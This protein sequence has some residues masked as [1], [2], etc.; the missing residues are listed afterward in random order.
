M[1]EPLQPFDWKSSNYERPANSWVCGRTCQSGEPCRLGPSRAGECQVQS[2]CQPEEKNGK[3][4]CTRSTINGGKCK[5]GPTPEGTCCQSDSQCQPRRTLIAKRRLLGVAATIMALSFSLLIFS[6]SSPSALL[7]PGEVTDS[8]ANFETDC[9]ACHSAAEGGITTWYQM[10]FDGETAFKDS[11]RCLKCHTD[12]GT[13]ALFAHGISVKKLSKVTEQTQSQTESTTVPF[14]LQLASLTGKPKANQKIACATC[15][16]EHHGRNANLTQLTDFQCQTCHIKQFSSFD[17]GHPKLGDYPY[18]RRSRIY[19]DHSTHLNHY[20]VKEEFKRTMP[21]GRKPDSCKSCHTINT[22]DGVMM[23]GSFEN[24]C[25]S[26][27][28]PQIKDL[29]FP[30][31]PFFAL[32]TI[33]A[34]M[35]KTQGEWPNTKGAF[36]TAKLP[37]FMELLLKHDTE[38]QKAIKHLGTIDY[39]SL[40]TLN[41]KQQKSVVK[42]AW[43]IKNLLYDLSLNGEL[44]LEKRL[45]SSDPKYLHLKPSII[46]TLSQ[47]Q[48]IW[49]PNLAAEIKAY[50][51]KK[52]LPHSAI[53]EITPESN[54][55]STNASNGWAI[56]N[57]DFTIR[58]RP[59]GHADP[60]LKGWLD[61]AVQENWNSLDS[62]SMWRILSNPTASGLED[63]N[64][65]LASGRCLMCHS[66]D[67]NPDSGIAQIN[68][69]PLPPQQK[70]EKLTQFS[71]TPHILENKQDNCLSCHQFDQSKE[72]IS[73]IFKSNYFVRDKSNLFWKIKTNSQEA[74]TSGFHPIS[75]KTCVACHN[76]TTETQ[77]CL[78][79]HQYHAHNQAKHK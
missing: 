39:R 44:A 3:Y 19:F 79:C 45:G 43:A 31:V 72:S 68:W 29:D 62:D 75:Q 23:T 4:Q 18:Q 78:Q 61:H 57:S 9:N 11:K 51:E 69:L 70:N 47:A 12:L 25:A 55:F 74:C 53:R 28:E 65:A 26:C 41:Q 17:H 6:G 77:S 49:F 54:R 1:T 40:S 71:H 32:P 36:K 33:P 10:A 42:I 66:V 50:Q 14:T 15:H 35:M 64:G 46:P 30:G 22:N 59:L 58:Y 34:K 67:K 21:S 24:T 13:E 38:Y 52:P 60:L 5:E 48:Q 2:V 37:Q 16:K 73:T 63:T 76:K 8:H 27:H 7:T 20:F 56:S